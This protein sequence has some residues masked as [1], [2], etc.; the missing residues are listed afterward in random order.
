MQIA[1]VRSPPRSPHAS[2]PLTL[3]TSQVLTCHC[4]SVCVHRGGRHR[5]RRAQPPVTA[6]TAP[7]A[8]ASTSVALNQLRNR[9]SRRSPA[10]ARTTCSRRWRSRLRRRH[11]RRS[12]P[13]RQ[14]QPPLR[15]AR[16]SRRSARSLQR[17]PARP[18]RSRGPGSP[19]AAGSAAPP[20]RHQQRG[21][22][23]H[24][25]GP[26]PL[27][28]H[29]PP[30]ASVPLGEAEEPGGGRLC[31][32]QLHAGGLPVPPTVSV[33]SRLRPARERRRAH[34]PLPER[35]RRV[36]PPRL[37][38]HSGAAPAAAGARREL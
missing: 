16:A 5:H 7:A 26:P 31:A 14:G 37:A 17:R 1:P 25:T 6:G 21:P 23:P 34:I 3:L 20:P 35:G 33:V 32:A 27:P 29:R 11:S 9:P 13:L 36:C 2:R 24:R 10:S 4:R 30:R 28:S 38:S 22:A 12:A 8:S 18:R 19:A 15:C